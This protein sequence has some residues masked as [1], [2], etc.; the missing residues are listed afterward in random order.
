MKDQCPGKRAV[1]RPGGE[2]VRGVQEAARS[3]CL[4]QNGE[5]GGK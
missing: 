4:E 3:P 5:S 1:G 2:S